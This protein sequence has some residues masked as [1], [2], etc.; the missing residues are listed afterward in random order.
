MQITFTLNGGYTGATF[1]AG[2]YNIS[3]TTSG[4]STYELANGVTKAQ[5]ITGHTVATVYE[6]L[7]GGTIQ[8][9][10]TCGTSQQW[11]VGAAP[12]N[13]F[14]F[15]LW[16]SEDNTNSPT[17]NAAYQTLT[18]DATEL[19]GTPTTD[20]YIKISGSPNVDYVYRF[21]QSIGDPADNVTV[22]FQG[23]PNDI[24]CDGNFPQ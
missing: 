4:G 13:T 22:I 19:T 1:V 24:Y 14:G 21:N 3:G 9:T 8:S 2:P 20:T 16:C 23:G 6:T 12:Q 10:G 15:D 18:V 17:A 7:T 11:Y 5:M